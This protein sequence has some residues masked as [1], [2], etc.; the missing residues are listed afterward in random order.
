MS[1]Q[2]TPGPWEH[3]CVHTFGADGRKD[4]PFHYVNSTNPEEARIAEIGAW[5]DDEITRANAGLIAAAPD[6]LESLREM[7]DHN[8]SVAMNDT[9][10]R[11]PDEVVDRAR[12]ALAKAGVR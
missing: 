10:Y 8:A 5:R 4:Q 7:L 1:A 9:H 6:L 2:H 3:R 11:A 12:A